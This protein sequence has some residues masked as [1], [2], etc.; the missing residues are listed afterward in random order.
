ML[1]SIPTA[2]FSY[3]EDNDNNADDAMGDFPDIG[4]GGHPPT[5]DG[6]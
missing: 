4:H 5:A 3:V 2:Y 1:R 6:F